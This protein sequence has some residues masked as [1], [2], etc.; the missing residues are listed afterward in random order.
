[1]TTAQFAAMTDRQAEGFMITEVQPVRARLAQIVGRKTVVDIGCGKGDE[2]SDLFDRQTYLGIDCSP[3]L[4]RIARRNNPGYRFE[5]ATNLRGHW[6]YAIIKSVLEHLPPAEAV[7]LY[8]LAR[9]VCDTLLVAWH[10]EPGRERLYWYQGELGQMM[11]HRHDR[12]AFSGTITRET[13]GKHAIWT[14]V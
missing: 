3:A 11:Q 10:T 1:M 8:D 2:V 7:A 14:V 12:G 9:T 13:C 6:D 4:V 5:V